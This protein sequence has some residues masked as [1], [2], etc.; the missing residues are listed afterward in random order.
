MSTI[1]RA[2]LGKFFAVSIRQFNAGHSAPEMFSTAIDAEWHRLMETPEYAEFSDRHAGQIL[3][4]TSNCGAGRISWISAYEEMYGSLPEIWFTDT[5]GKVDEQAL[6]RYRETGVVV[7]EW[8]CSPAPDGD[9][10]PEPK[11][12]TI[13]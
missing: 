8:D 1:E 9:A 10:V 3:G 12:A 7:A 5:D 2:E 6:A 13:R 11:T 4:H